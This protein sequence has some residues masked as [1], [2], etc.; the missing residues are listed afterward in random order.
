MKKALIAAGAVAV[1]L[2]LFALALAHRAPEEEIGP[3]TADTPPA[4][5]SSA[6]PSAPPAPRTA[7]APGTAAAKAHQGFLYGRVHT[8]DGVTYEGRLRWGGDEEGFWGNYFNGFKADNPWAAEAPPEA[9]KERRPV[10]LF[11]VKIAE[12][13]SEIELTRPFMSRFGDIRLI[14]AEGRD[15]RVTLKSGTVFHLDRHRADDFADGLR[16]W[17]GDGGYVDLGERR[18]RSVELLPT[19]RLG[20]TPQRL[21]GTART[22]EGDFTGFIQWNRQEGMGFDELDGRTAD[23]EASRRFDTIRSIVRHSDDSSRV[24]LVDGSEIVLSGSR[25]AGDGNRGLY[26]EDP[27]YGRVLI[28]WDAFERLDFNP[29]DSGPAYGD[30]PPGSP[31]TG[32]VTTRDGRR[33]T[34]RLVYDLDESETTETLDAPSGGVDYAIHFGLVASIQLPGSKDGGSGGGGPEDS[35][36]GRATVTLHGGEE[37]RLEPSG[38]LGA[39][40]AGLLVFTAARE[41]PD[42]V[43]WAEVAE[44]TFD[45]PEAMYP[46][47][48]GS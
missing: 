33:L 39:A 1:M 40:N 38:D 13:D 48:G 35:S 30:F 15:L 37:L 16:V 2:I 19:P 28:S 45:R 14:E 31:L 27:R 36:P 42:Y 46:P 17:D 3:A 25:E 23:G 43:P 21:H 44:I 5:P 9:L 7:A 47:P 11:G 41:R 4:T 24:T 18:M 12:R 6:S 26:V 20:A 32:T 34:G 10:E 22:P 8:V 29:A